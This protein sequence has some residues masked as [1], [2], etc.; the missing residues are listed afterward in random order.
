MGEPI[1][2]RAGRRRGGDLDRLRVP[3]RTGERSDPVV[4]LRSRAVQPD[5]RV[6]GECEVDWRGTFRK[7]DDVARWGE[8][9]DLVLIEIQLEK[10][11]ELIRRLG[12]HLQLE[13]L[14]KPGEVAIELVA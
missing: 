3:Q 6:H 9:E 8:D 5:L 1:A 2:R 7:L 4:D 13:H 11:E 14:A 12:V 10:L